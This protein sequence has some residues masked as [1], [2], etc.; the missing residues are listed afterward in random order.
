LAWKLAFQQ[1]DW[2]VLFLIP[3]T[4]LLFGG[5]YKLSLD[6]WNA[7]FDLTV[8]QESKFYS[9]LTGKITATIIGVIF[10][11]SSITILAWQTLQASNIKLTMMALFAAATNIIYLFLQEYIAKHFHD[12][13]DRNISV[14]ITTLAVSIVCFLFLWYHA[15]HFE[16]HSGKLINADFSQ[17]I[18]IGFSKVPNQESLFANFLAIPFVHET[19]K[20]WGLI[21]I[22]DSSF[23]GPVSLIMCLDAALISFLLVRANVILVQFIQVTKI[24]RDI[25]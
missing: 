6:N 7:K 18:E 23:I 4:L 22:K 3:L 10:S 21:Q 9:I 14:R 5:S 24:L 13:F 8:K 19:L 20:V 1:S 12:P 11:F 2:S 15:F 25:S 17:A 16:T